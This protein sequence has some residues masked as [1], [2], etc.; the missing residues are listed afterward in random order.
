MNAPLVLDREEWCALRRAAR[1]LDVAKGGYWRAYRD[2]RIAFFCGPDRPAPG[3]PAVL[4]RGP[5][6]EP[7]HLVGMAVGTPLSGGWVRVR[8]EPWDEQFASDLPVW[9]ARQFERLRDHA[10]GGLLHRVAESPRT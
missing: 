3:A 9:L 10:E 7:R 1:D 2:G 4:R 5:W 8:I 6:Q